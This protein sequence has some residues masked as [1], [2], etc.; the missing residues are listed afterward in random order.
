MLMRGCMCAHTRPREQRQMPR[1]QPASPELRLVAN[2][3][4][5]LNRAGL[6]GGKADSRA[7]WEREAVDRPAAAVAPESKGM[8]RK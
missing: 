3:R 1:L 6:P 5:A 7:G 4:L 8:L 2:H